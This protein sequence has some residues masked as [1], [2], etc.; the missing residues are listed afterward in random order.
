MN[1]IMEKLLVFYAWSCGAI[2]VGA[3]GYI[4]GYL[5]YKGASSLNLSLIFGEVNPLDALLLR[6]PVFDGLFP[7]I[8][9]TLILVLLSVSIA[10]PI[11]MAAGIYMAEYANDKVRGLFGVFFDILAG[12]PSIVIGL[13]GFSVS[14]FLHHH[15]SESIYPSLIVSALS[16]AFL[17][18]PYLIR[19]TQIA[20]ESIPQNI[21]MTAMALGAERLQNIFYVL[22]PHSLSGIASG[23]VL[24][25]GRCAEDTAVIMLTG[26]VATAGIPKSIMANFEALPFYIYYISS[27]YAD[28]DELAKGFGAAIILIMICAAL[29]SLAFFIKRRLSNHMLYKF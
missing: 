7:A 2:L 26:V 10:I 19:T 4:L 20:L 16:L 14:V 24:S 12:I 6:Q 25:I 8:I 3:V 28:S 17:V 22:I 27:Q 13:F 5:F 9:G 29:L 18:L 21:R 15:F 23:V 11:G 1:R